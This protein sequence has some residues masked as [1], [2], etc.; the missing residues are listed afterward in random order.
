MKN[1]LYLH[2][3]IYLIL[4]V[5]IT[6]IVIFIATFS[7]IFKSFNDLFDGYCFWSCV[8]VCD[9]PITRNPGIF[10]FI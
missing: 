7:Y 9:K 6:V 1:K 4:I 10:F 3:Y 5:I 2:L 8:V